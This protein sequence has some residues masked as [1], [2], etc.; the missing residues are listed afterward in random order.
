MDLQKR[1]A[2]VLLHTTSLP[3][4]HGIGDFG[5]AAFQFVD[6]LVAAGQ[7][8]WQLLPTA[9]IGPG[10]FAVP[11]RVGLRRQPA[12]GG[13]GAAGG[14]GLAR[15]AGAAR[16][17]L[18]RASRSTTARSIP[19]RIAA[20]A[21]RRQG[22][23]RRSAVPSER[24]AFAAW[25]AEAGARW[26]D[27]YALFM[28]LESPPATARLVGSGRTACSAATP[29]ALA[30]ARRE[31]ADEIAVL[32][33]RAVAVRRA[34]GARSRS[35]PTSAASSSWATCRSS[36]RTTARTCGRGPTCTRS[37]RTSSPPS[38]PA[39]RPTRWP[40]TASAGATRCT[41]GIAWPTRTSPGGRPA[42]AARWSRPTCSAS[43]TSAASPATTR[44]PA[45]CP[46]AREGT[47]RT[48]PGKPLFDAI[49]QGARPA[50]HRGRGP[51]LH[52]PGRATT[53]AT[54]CG[55]PGMRIL[56]FAFGGDADRRPSCRTT[57]CRNTIAYTGTHDNDTA[58][59]W[60]DNAS[61]HERAYV[62]S[63]LASGG[64]DIHWAM[65][66]ACCN[67]V[68]NVADLPAA[69]RAGP[70]QRPPHEHAGHGGRP[71]LVVALRLGRC[72]ARSRGGCWG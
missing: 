38:S 10:E 9:P 34:A 67:S 19:W 46:T 15:R 64:D 47:W 4:P 53:C 2:G 71:E 27:D 16:G 63:Y 35:T 12:D 29:K 49:A 51:G 66:R 30:A 20:A 55:Y 68:A 32:A 39:A 54:A 11:E 44:S 56:Q 50:A 5:P 13:A 23:C 42:C 72:W 37:T 26:L 33:V 45:S 65:I 59:G 70:G 6:W 3:G 69:G 24:A 18:R 36:S 62:G 52:H 57:T 22:L 14:Q 17:R 43:T 60:W 58:R 25:C 21:R 48:G 28:A 61:P 1:S 8:V 31:H 40:S 7:S 41:T